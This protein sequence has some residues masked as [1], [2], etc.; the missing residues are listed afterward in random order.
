MTDDKN[1]IHPYYNHAY[2]RYDI[3]IDDVITGL[4]KAGYMLDDDDYEGEDYVDDL[5]PTLRLEILSTKGTRCTHTGFNTVL[6]PI[7]FKN[8][9]DITDS[10]PASNFKWVRISGDDE[11]SRL[12]DSEWNLRHAAGSKE[13]YI[14]KDDIR[15]NTTFICKYVE[16]VDQDIAYGNAAY[17]T[18][19]QNVN[20]NGGD[21]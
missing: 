5:D 16:L 1:L 11:A 7:L 12:S 10:V 14:T 4:K 21:K 8:N 9:E 19:I 18:Y 17:K 15:N 6:Y 3:D 2:S 13:C 20:K